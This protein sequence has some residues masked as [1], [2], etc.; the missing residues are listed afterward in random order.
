[1]TFSRQRWLFLIIILPV[2]VIIG[3]EDSEKTP[4]ETVV[5][6]DTT[7]KQDTFP[8]LG[9]DGP[10]YPDSVYYG[11][12]K[13]V[14][15]HAGDLPI[16]LSAPHGGRITPDEIPD[17]SYGTTVTDDNTYELTKTVM[18]TM[19]ARFGG[20]PHVILCRLKRTK[21]DANRDSVEAAQDDKYALRAW[22]EYHH[23]I[24]VAK[25]K[26][27]TDYGS[28]LFLDM[29]G[30][31][32]NP[33]GFYDLRNWLGYL[34]SGS[35]LDLSDEVLNTNSIKNKTSIRALVDSSSYSF[36]EVLR[37]ANSF[38]AILDSLGFKSVPSVNDP[39]PNGMR[40]FSGGYNT[41]RHGSKNGGMISAIQ[42][43]APKPGIREN[44]TTWSKFSSAFVSTIYIYY[45]RH[46][47]RD[48]SN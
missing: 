22:Q 28:G 6:Q 36:I 40:Y 19:V 24:G 33:D 4:E 16:I 43:E 47:N 8:S 38:G 14:E 12:E 45:T 3:C 20:R 46:L 5:P 18:D 21:L 27:E 30:H 35:E 7:T 44:Q 31:G 48:L 26:I 11:R 37:G 25:K 9:H 29:H 10:Y 39:G 2:T 1:M 41:G 34:L 32:R 42:V 13:Y 17:R 23:Y 15:Y